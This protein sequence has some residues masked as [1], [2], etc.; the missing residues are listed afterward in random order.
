MGRQ[1]HAI[2]RQTV[3]LTVANLDEAWPLQQRASALFQRLG[4][5]LERHF[6]ALGAP[7]FLHRIDRL[8]LDLGVLAAGRLEQDLPDRLGAA[9]RLA[10]AGHLQ[11]QAT[12]DPPPRLASALELFTHFVR[13]GYLPWWADLARP[14]QP[15]AALDLL[16]REA[17]ALLARRLPELA[18][19]RNALRRLAAQFEDRPL[20]ALA[21]LAAPAL[22]GFLPPL[23]TVLLHLP[24]AAPT[25]FRSQVWQSLLPAVVLSE[26]PVADRLDFSRGV[27]LRLAQRQAMPY[28]ALVRACVEMST[29]APGAVRVVAAALAEECGLAGSPRVSQFH[30]GADAPQAPVAVEPSTGLSS[31]NFQAEPG[32]AAPPLHTGNAPARVRPELP[33]SAM[34]AS[35]RV[36]PTMGVM[37]GEIRES[38]DRPANH[39]GHPVPP[40]DAAMPPREPPSRQPR[41]ADDPPGGPDA[42]HSAPSPPGPS[43]GLVDE[44]AAGFSETG[45]IY[46]DNAG[47]VILWPFLKSLFDRLGLLRE[48]D[49]R[50]AAA[51]QRGVIL[52]HYLAS[53]LTEPPEYLLPL[54]KLL[55]GLDL[56]TVFEPETALTEAETAEGEHLLAA[57]IDQAPILNHMSIQGFRGSFLLRAG[58]LSVRDGA[59]LLRVE[60]ETY[61]LVLERFPWGFAWVK[62]PWMPLPLRVEW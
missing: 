31:R 59:W 51:R 36:E 61:D 27:L 50:D 55:C 17:P 48:A 7:E 38:L 23:A 54:N 39:A 26:P 53:G 25:T 44:S 11:R 46:L 33:A 21:V 15:Q 12:G 34:P 58:A 14:G 8:E 42:R 13:Q 43:A 20:I 19:D 28:P 22:G 2:L 10:L 5:W 41:P 6:D 1:R 32:D 37:D 49:F 62:L 18:Q 4:P 9:L 35:G 30:W 29:D 16:L 3:E 52:L 40:G 47:L 56:E 24:T 57:V 45:A 60:R